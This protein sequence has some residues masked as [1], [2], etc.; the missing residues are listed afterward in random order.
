M[1]VAFAVNQTDYELYVGKILS[2]SWKCLERDVLS[3][4][5]LCTVIPHW[6]V[7]LKRVKSRIF[8]LACEIAG[9][10]NNLRHSTVYG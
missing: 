6:H 8:G 3:A 9:L 1:S 10:L 4:P 5:T 7:I 2:F